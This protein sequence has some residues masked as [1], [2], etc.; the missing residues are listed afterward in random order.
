[1]WE[2]KEDK[3]NVLRQDD[4]KKGDP[5]LEFVVAAPLAK[6]P[7]EEKVIAPEGLEKNAKS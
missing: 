3:Q 6:A 1:M 7:T 4:A 5:S 2:S